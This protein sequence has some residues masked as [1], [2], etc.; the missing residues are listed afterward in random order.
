MARPASD[1]SERIVRAARDRFLVEGVDGAS[2]RAI[3][4]DAGTSLGMVYYYFPTK[5]DLFLAIV[6]ALYG[7][8]L[9]ELSSAAGDAALD[10]HERIERVYARLA[11][12]S[13]E[14]VAVVRLILREGMSSSSQRFARLFERFMRGHV[15]LLA[16]LL[17]TGAQKG[18]VR[19]DVPALAMVMATLT[20]GLIPQ[21]LRRRLAE[22]GMPVDALL[23]APPDLAKALSRVLLEGITP[24]SAE[25]RRRAD[26]STELAPEPARPARPRGAASRSRTKGR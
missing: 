14:E 9:E 22:S 25:P 7:K 24:R 20:T 1:I 8:L 16:A 23:P 18:E 5:D 10:T 26:A 15:G 6:E 12:L 2:L 13:D 3:A 17:H 11:A 4:R 19:V 21:I